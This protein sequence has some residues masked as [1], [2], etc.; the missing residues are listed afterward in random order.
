MA[1]AGLRARVRAPTLVSS[2]VLV[3]RAWTSLARFV[4]PFVLSSPAS[5]LPATRCPRLNRTMLT[6]GAVVVRGSPRRWSGRGGSHNTCRLWASTCSR[7]DV[8]LRAIPAPRVHNHKCCMRFKL[9]G[10]VLRASPR[11]WP[12]L[13]AITCSVSSA[14]TRASARTYERAIA[15]ACAACARPH[16]LQCVRLGERRHVRHRSSLRTRKIAPSS[17]APP[18]AGCIS[19]RASDFE[20]DDACVRT[21]PRQR[22]RGCAR[23]AARAPAREAA[24]ATALRPHTRK[25]ARFRPRA[26]SVVRCASDSVF[27]SE[28]DV[29]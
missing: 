4:R 25:S 15:A 9:R 20:S 14:A 19:H 24:C 21:F 11:V 7:P 18:V 22:V 16:E 26:F 8:Q 29:A 2:Y 17:R 6:Y 3:A 5:P 13:P 28:S 10:R 12:R 1:R 23:V 27:F